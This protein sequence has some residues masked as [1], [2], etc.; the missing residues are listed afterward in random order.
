VGLAA[1]CGAG[2]IALRSYLEAEPIVLSTSSAVDP[3]PPNGLVTDAA[4]TERLAPLH[5]RFDDVG[6]DEE[7]RPVGIEDDGELEIPDEDEIGWWEYGSAPGLPGA[8][9]L[10]AH[11][12]WHDTAGPFNRLGRAEIGE[13]LEV[14]TGEGTTRVYQVVERTM[15]PKDELPR[16][17]IWR[18]TGPETLVLITCG[19]DYN[20]NIRRYRHNIVVYAVPIASYDTPSDET[21]PD[22][23]PGTDRDSVPDSDPDAD[24]D[25]D[26]DTDVD[27][28]AEASGQRSEAEF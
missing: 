3:N 21:I 8:T 20:P 13:R 10:A 6:V 7:I 16:W 28:E 22:P 2:V 1:A 26:P 5:L 18:T 25:S 11:V 15:Y 12:S 23:D 14:D 17:R 19:G 27:A 9:V 24:R 4:A